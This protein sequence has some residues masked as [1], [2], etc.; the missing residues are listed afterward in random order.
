MPIRDDIELPEVVRQARVARLATVSPDGHP[1]IVPVVFA[2]SG[3]TIV[4]PL[5]GKPKSGRKLRRVA[6]IEREPRV[7]LLVDHY[8]E[9]WSRLSWCRIDG[10]ARIIDAHPHAH[11]LL[12]DKYPQYATVPLGTELIELAPERVSQWSA[13]P[14]ARDA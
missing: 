7:S 2:V 5:D 12:R 1:H 6:N 9:D 8:Q 4:I 11:Q 13:E 10:T 14:P 3:E